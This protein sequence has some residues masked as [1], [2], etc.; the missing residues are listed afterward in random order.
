MTAKA[1]DGGAT[2]FLGYPFFEAV[3]D[4]VNS[5]PEFSRATQ[6]F[7]GAV[8]LR[9]G[10]LDVWMKWYRG[11]IIDM[12]EGIDPLGQTFSL[13]APLE[14]WRGII[15]LPRTSYRP[16]AKLFNFGEIATEGNIV[17]ASRVLEAQFIF[18]SHIEKLG[19]AAQ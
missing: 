17:E 9:I 16:W 19:R 14:T 6:W 10:D 11:Q 4:S 12:H 8:L 18:V 13:V 1:D 5:D 3:R 15:D 2:E 7:D